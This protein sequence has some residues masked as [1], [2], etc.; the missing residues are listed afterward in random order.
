MS[1]TRHLKTQARSG[2]VDR[3]EPRGVP[4]AEMAVAIV[5][6]NTRVQL[7]ACLASALP[8]APASVVVADNAS[9]DGSVELVRSTYPGVTLVANS[10]NRGYGAAA[11]QA[12]GASESPYVLLLNSDTRLR[13]GALAALAS[14]LES[15]PAAGVVGPRLLNVDGSP[16]PSCFPFPTPLHTF[17]QTTFFGAL[18]QRVPGVRARYRPLES[19]DVPSRVPCVLGAAL[20]IRRE[21]FAAAGGFDESF[22]MYSEEVDLAARLA[23]AGWEVHYTPLAEVVHVGGASTEQQ[24]VEMEARRYL[25]TRQFYRKH[26]S[27]RQQRLLV[28]MTTYRMLHNLALDA[29]RVAWSRGAK[30]R[31]RLATRRAVWRR[32]LRE[33]WRE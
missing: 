9:S 3:V 27:R 22:F 18:A 10:V 13:P 25:A 12:V 26:Y 1:E 7:G 16:Q 30:Q 21:A 11:N 29:A 6:F 8:E 20:A 24:P 4:S 15:H 19:P 17:L 28:A 2:K 33:T 23:A 14:H 31:S 5:S 32:V